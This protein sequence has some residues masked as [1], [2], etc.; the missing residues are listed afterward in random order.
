MGDQFYI[1]PLQLRKE[2]IP[3]EKNY[4][5][6]LLQ[7]ALKDRTINQTCSLQ[8]VMDFHLECPDY[9]KKF[10]DP[11]EAAYVKRQMYNLLVLPYM[12]HRMFEYEENQKMK[13]VREINAKNKFVEYPEEIKEVKPNNWDHLQRNQ[14]FLDRFYQG[15]EFQ[16]DAPREEE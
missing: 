5:F 1:P 10:D 14:E 4:L 15:V 8:G 13:E 3:L 2:C 9:L 6:C 12:Q 11:K 7:K 16:A